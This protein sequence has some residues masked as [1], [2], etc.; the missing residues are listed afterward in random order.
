MIKF[1]V[2]NKNQN[3]MKNEK[4][5]IHA[6]LAGVIKSVRNQNPGLDK[7]LLELIDNSVDADATEITIREDEGDLIISDNGNGFDDIVRSLDYGRSDKEGK[8][9]R[10]GVGLKHACARYSDDTTII[11]NGVKVIAP[12]KCIAEGATN[13]VECSDAENGDWTHISL[14]G[15]R[16]RYKWPVKTDRI[17][18]VYAPFLLDDKNTISVN[19]KQLEPLDKPIFTKN[20]DVEFNYQG[21]KVHLYGGIFPP[22]DPMR[23]EWHGYNT[24][25]MGRLIGDG[26]ITTSGVGE[27]F[28]CTNF[29]FII[30]L[31]DGDEESWSLATL[32]DA[33]IGQKELLDYCYTEHTREL[34][35]EASEQAK[36]IDLIHTE[37]LV[38]QMLGGGNQKR[39]KTT[40][41]RGSIEPKDTGLT[42]KRTFTDD[43]D[44]EY[45][46]SGRSSK[47]GSMRFK[48]DRFTAHDIGLLTR[49]G[50][51]WLFSANLS[52]QWVKRNEKNPDALY[53]MARTIWAAMRV[54]DDSQLT[55]EDLIDSIV[56]LAGEETD[57]EEDI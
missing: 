54:L 35:K 29:C 42:K 46:S 45:Q 27:E 33:F 16:E 6:T 30:D 37:N 38:N 3:T 13:D 26:R 5:E 44:G 8:I 31:E 7:A 40:G 9:G 22:S 21:K 41:K 4:K 48:L 1:G 36:E 11:S 17:R 18:R 24:Y 28:I 49:H 20:I 57:R 53:G 12:W 10:Y 51:G 15:F 55:A 19:G 39:T 2:H 25:Y 52:N 43:S 32:K 50:N 14:G 47:K 34:L 23:K 56:K